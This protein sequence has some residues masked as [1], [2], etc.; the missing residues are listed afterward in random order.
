LPTAFDFA[1]F[2]IPP[3]LPGVSLKPLVDGGTLER[4][5]SVAIT[6][7]QRPEG[8]G[9]SIRNREWKHIR[10]PYGPELYH[11]ESDPYEFVNLADD[12]EYAL[13]IAEL[14]ASLIA[15]YRWVFNRA[16]RQWTDYPTQAWNVLTL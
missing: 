11:I 1:G 9:L 5:R 2:D 7:L 15:E 13:E 10:G 16:S 4:E 8:I 12:P 3:H 6:E 14:H